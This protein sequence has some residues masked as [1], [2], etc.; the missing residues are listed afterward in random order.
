MHAQKASIQFAV[1][2]VACLIHEHPIMKQEYSKPS[3]RLDSEGISVYQNLDDF[4]KQSN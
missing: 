4:N 2:H 3:H 1:R